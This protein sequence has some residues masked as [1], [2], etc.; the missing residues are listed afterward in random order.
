MIK[1]TPLL[2]DEAFEGRADQPTPPGQK[3][4]RW[5]ETWRR[6]REAGGQI[7]HK[8]RREAPLDDVVKRHEFFKAHYGPWE[9]N[10]ERSL[11][12]RERTDPLILA[13]RERRERLFP[14]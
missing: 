11:G 13:R 12:A 1:R 2:F 14:K 4:D 9:R 6:G 8:V 5:K 3:R 10:V 7:G